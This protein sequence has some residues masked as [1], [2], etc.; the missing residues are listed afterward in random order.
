MLFI[1][2]RGNAE[3][4]EGENVEG[5]SAGFFYR[6]V[7]RELRLRCGLMFLGIVC[8]CVCVYVCM[9]SAFNRA[10]F[11]LSLLYG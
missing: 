9:K 5:V 4:S 3:V 2:G 1:S 6:V 7:Y 8:V 10:V 11:L